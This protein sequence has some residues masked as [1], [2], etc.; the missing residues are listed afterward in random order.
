MDEARSVLITGAGRG[1]GRALWGVYGDAGWRTFPVVRTERAAGERRR[2][3]PNRCHPIIA[4]LADDGAVARIEAVLSK[5]CETLD[6]AI[7]C[8]RSAATR[9]R[10]STPTAAAS[11]KAAVRSRRSS[12]GASWN[13][14]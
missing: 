13:S 1:L 12:R 11:T 7:N 4:D 8:A 6:A 9:A 14:R 3:E 2:A 5:H 10:G